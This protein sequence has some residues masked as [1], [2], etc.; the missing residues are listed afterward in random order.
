MLLCCPLLSADNLLSPEIN[1]YFNCSDNW[2]IHLQESGDFFFLIEQLENLHKRGLKNLVC[3]CTHC[4]T[5]SIMNTC[6][7]KTAFTLSDMES[8][9][10][11]ITACFLIAASYMVEVIQS[12]FIGQIHC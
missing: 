4:E 6:A 2:P 1:L 10:M 11:I 3:V 5:Q 9:A 7:P 12:K 8:G